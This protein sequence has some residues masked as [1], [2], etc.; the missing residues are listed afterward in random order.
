MA[1]SRTG[2]TTS[3][4]K[5][6]V[7]SVIYQVKKNSDGTYTQIVYGKGVRTE[8]TFTP[9]LQAQRMCTAMVENLMKQLKQIG[10]ISFQSGKNKSQS[11]NAFGSWNLRKVQTDCK[12]NW[13][14]SQKFVYPTRFNTK[15]EI[16]DLGG[17]YII[18][19]GSLQQNIFDR[20]YYDWYAGA[21]W[22]GASDPQDQLYGV[23]FNCQI[24]VT[25]VG[26]FLTAHRMTRM[27]KICVAGFREWISYEPDPD[28]PVGYM[29]HSWCIASLA[30]TIQD[31]EVMTEQLIRDLFILES[32]TN[33]KI[34]MARD[35]QSF[36]IGFDADYYHSDEIYYY[37]ATFSIS[38][39]KGKKLIS[40]S[41]YHN[42]DGGDDPWWYGQQ[43]ANVFGSWMGEPTRV[44]YPSP[45]E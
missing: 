40:S 30:Y 39:V 41:T 8:T 18:S 26:E 28:D 7:G 10:R 2:G 36:F 15:K 35:G 3:K 31:N 24:G 22:I 34:L 4:L 14:G 23:Q 27:D 44:P 16:Q 37:M 32:D 25:K 5:G 20:E 43:P 21:R 13:Y 33:A 29:R 17:P 12:A 6:Q 1:T 9:K 38:Y 45:F 19:S 11:L 42:P